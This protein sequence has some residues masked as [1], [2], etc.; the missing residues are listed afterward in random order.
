MEE[1]KKSFI[2]TAKEFGKKHWKKALLGAGAVIGGIA[3]L[4]LAKGKSD[5][6]GIDLDESEDDVVESVEESVQ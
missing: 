2:T 6:L 1:T 4:G 3:L 5:D